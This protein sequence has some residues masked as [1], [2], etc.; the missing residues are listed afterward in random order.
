MGDAGGCAGG[1]AAGANMQVSGK[2]QGGKEQ[3]KWKM[4]QF[5]QEGTCRKGA[6]CTF[7]HGDHELGTPIAPGLAKG[8]GFGGGN[9]GGQQ[10]GKG[11]GKMGGQQFS[12]A[13]LP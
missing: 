11:G 2:G 13:K 7:A 9:M 3:R 12:Q 1:G 4:C 10:F 5:W 6:S 8:G